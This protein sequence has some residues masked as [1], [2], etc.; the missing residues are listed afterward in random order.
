MLFWFSQPKPRSKNRAFPRP[1]SYYLHF[2]QLFLCWPL[3]ASVQVLLRV[4]IYG[5][6][7]SEHGLCYSV[8][9]YMF[10]EF[11]WLHLVRQ[12]GGIEYFHT[13]ETRRSS[14]R[15]INVNQ[16]VLVSF[17]LV[18]MLYVTEAGAVCSLPWLSIQKTQ[19]W[20]EFKWFILK[21]QYLHT[22]KIWLTWKWQLDWC[23]IING[24]LHRIREPWVYPV[25]HY[26]H[27]SNM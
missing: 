3:C 5:I 15:L 22:T 25:L 20:L 17:P 9:Y 14:F 8:W 10:T 19:I 27:T 2:S 26:G 21:L 12:K 11:S 1:I 6:Q 7:H 16:P 24:T 23:Y 13:K 18:Q 4:N